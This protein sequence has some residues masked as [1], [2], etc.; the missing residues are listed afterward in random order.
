MPTFY[1]KILK[2]R[3][4]QNG[5]LSLWVDFEEWFISSFGYLIL[6]VLIYQV[7]C[8]SDNT[9][10]YKLIFLVFGYLLDAT[11][12]IEMSFLFKAFDVVS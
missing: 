12:N 9:T 8:A 6:P 3:V 11:K 2:E 1:F 5:N 4:L 10:I 7:F